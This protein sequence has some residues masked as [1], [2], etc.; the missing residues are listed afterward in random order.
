METQPRTKV[1]WTPGEVM[2]LAGLFVMA[3][4]LSI[5]A[6][7]VLFWLKNGFWMPYTVW[8][9]LNDLAIP[10]PDLHTRFAGLQE[11]IDWLLQ[12]VFF[13]PA[14]TALMCVGALISYIGIRR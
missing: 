1:R 14:S 8:L 10:M 4:G 12:L 7:Q 2:K 11:I 3:I 6:W 9:A 13:L 5:F